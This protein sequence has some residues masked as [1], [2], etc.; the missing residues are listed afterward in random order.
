MIL[1]LSYDRTVKLN[2]I[3]LENFRNHGFFALDLSGTGDITYLVGPNA[4]GK[5]NVLEAIYILA[6]TKS[7]RGQRLEDLI[8]WSADYCRVSAEIDVAGSGGALK[9]GEKHNASPT[10]LEIFLGMPPN[11]RQ[12]LKV[13]GVKKATADFIGNCGVVL[14]HPE[15]L[16]MLYLGPELRRRYLDMLLIQADRGYFRA[17]ARYRRILKQRNSLI[18]AINERRAHKNELEVWDAQLAESGAIIITERRKTVDF[19]NSKLGA[20]YRRIAGND[21]EARVLYRASLVGAISG[22]RVLSADTIARLLTADEAE[23]RAAFLNA[24]NNALPTDLRAEVTTIGPHRDELEFTL[25][26]RPLASHASRGEYRSLLL[27]VKML[28]IE[29]LRQRR[30]TNPILLLDD[31]FSELDPKRQRQLTETIGDVQTI[32]TASHPDDHVIAS[33]RCNV[34]RIQP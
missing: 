5:T 2:R 27:A 34:I 4:S 7:F 19:L 16:N 15:D 3:K 29:Y 21:D 11:P 1:S 23:I 13:N 25:N 24:L 9:S 18:K 8:S 30:G 14:F 22:Q 20:N 31:V 28:E 33:S 10:S 6:L 17:L 12:S 26:G 32:I